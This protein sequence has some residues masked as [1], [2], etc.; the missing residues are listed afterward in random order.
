VRFDDP[1]LPVFRTDIAADQYEVYVVVSRFGSSLW[2][3]GVGD[4]PPPP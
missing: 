2:R 3:I 1:D 4:R